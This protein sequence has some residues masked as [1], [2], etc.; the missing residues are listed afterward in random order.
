MF[1]QYRSSD[2]RDCYRSK[3]PDL[4]MVCEGG[5]KI[6]ILSC[7][8]T[9]DD[10]TYTDNTRPDSRNVRYKGTKWFDDEVFEIGYVVCFKS[11][12][13]PMTIIAIDQSSVTCDWSFKDD[14]KS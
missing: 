14:A 4:R 6:Q 5:R 10:E 2:D 11:G 7:R 9:H 8:S 13:H 12:G 3:L 1:E